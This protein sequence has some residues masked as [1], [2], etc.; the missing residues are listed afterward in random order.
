MMNLNGIVYCEQLIF[1]FE[2]HLKSFTTVIL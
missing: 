2:T 1:S